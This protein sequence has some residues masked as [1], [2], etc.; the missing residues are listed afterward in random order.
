MGRSGSS[1]LSRVLSLCGCGLPGELVGATEANPLGHW[2]PHEALTLN[3]AFLATHGAN[4]FDPTL[5]L[6]CEGAIDPQQRAGFIEM[7]KEFLRSMPGAPLIVVK[8]PR[9]TA[10]SEYWFAA[11]RELGFSLGVVIPVRHPQEVVASLRVRDQA[12]P[13]LSSA[14]WLK[15]NLLGE[16]QSRG[17]ARVFVDYVKLLS[18]WREELA[19]ISA[20]LS[21]DLSARD[22]AAIDGFLRHDLRR[23][24]HSGRVAEVFGQP[25]ISRVYAALC[26]AARDEPL[27]TAALDEVFESYRACERA[28][29][30]ALED[31]AGRRATA[32]VPAAPRPGDARNPDL[33]R[34]ICAVAPRD[35]QVL[36]QCFTSLWYTMRNPDV[37][38]ARLDPYQHWLAF[39]ANEGRLPCEDTLAL[40]ETLMRE[41][42]SRQI[43]PAAT[44]QA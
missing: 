19:R 1:A 37:V 31:F 36:R 12:S 14:L 29:R 21:L 25:W 34:L 44:L 30:V 8:E 10:L 24:R 41:R 3:D 28:F 16:R 18:D 33:A 7:I 38:A 6:Q 27:D 20:A 39:G 42:T 17:V 40:L 11:V 26:A 23:Q 13:E 35:S 5:R 43:A 15:Y 4:W 9:I 32:P 2:E 22:D